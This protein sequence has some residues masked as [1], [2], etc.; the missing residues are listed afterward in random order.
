M[1]YLTS[2]RLLIIGAGGHG[3]S[4]AEAAELSG[5][6]QVLGFLDDSFSSEADVLGRPVLGNLDSLPL[7]RSLFDTVIIAI[8]NNYVRQKLMHQVADAG[9]PIATVIHPQAYV[10]PSAQ[11]GPGSSVMSGA[12]VGTAANLGMGVI[13]SSGAVVDHHAR[14]DD[15]GHLGVNASMAGGTVLGSCAWMQAGSSIAYGVAL[16]AGTI[17]L[18]AQGV[19]E[20]N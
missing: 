8:G 2:N 12:I 13:V 16:E 7:F 20:N 1:A 17:L 9:Y 3:Q 14:V 4:V 15:F 11:L 18:P 5:K 10:A 6:F 19:S